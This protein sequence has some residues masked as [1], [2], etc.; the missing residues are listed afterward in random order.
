VLL[1]TDEGSLK[2]FLGILNS[3]LLNYIYQFLSSEEGKT[4]AQVKT[5]LVEQLPVVYDKAKEKYLVKLVD[6]LI[7]MRRANPGIDVSGLESELDE[8]V[9]DLFGLNE[10]E[11]KLILSMSAK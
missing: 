5:G 2:Y 8:Y 1:K 11:K 7:E 9:C 6:K 4:L 3:R 10:D